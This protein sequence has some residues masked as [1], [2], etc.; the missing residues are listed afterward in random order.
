MSSPQQHSTVAAAIAHNAACT[1]WADAR[2]A[3]GRLSEDLSIPDLAGQRLCAVVLV[4]GL[5]AFADTLTDSRRVAMG[6]PY[7]FPAPTVAGHAGSISFGFVAGQAVLVFAGRNHL[8]EGHSAHTVVHNVRVAAA[9]GAQTVIL[10]NAAGAVTDDLEVGSLVRIT[11]HI[12]LTGANPLT[13]PHDIPGTGFVDLSAAYSQQAALACPELRTGVYAAFAGPSYETP[14][15]VRMAR[16]LG[17][18]L[19]GM[20]TVPEAIAAMQLGLEVIGLSLVTN[21]AA[22]LGG[23][24]S[25]C[26]VAA[27]GAAATSSVVQTLTALLQPEI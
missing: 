24:L 12:N 23:P 2:Y 27:V 8:Y 16:T 25:H 22:G 26:E 17:A 18:N 21:R 4:S 3:A 11:D 9:L 7:L 14:A 20:S 10:T 15:E 1:P 13:G 19:V 5:G 6:A